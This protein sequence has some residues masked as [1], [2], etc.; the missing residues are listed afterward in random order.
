MTLIKGDNDAK[1]CSK[2]CREEA[3]SKNNISVKPKRIEKEVALELIPIEI[4]EKINRKRIQ[5]R[6]DVVNIN[7]SY[8]NF[9]EGINNFLTSISN[10][11]DGYEKTNSEIIYKSNNLLKGLN[12]Q[13]DKILHLNDIENSIILRRKK[14]METGLKYEALSIRKHIKL[15]TE[16]YASGNHQDQFEN[17]INQTLNFIEQK[18]SKNNYLAT[19]YDRNKLYVRMEEKW[20]ENYQLFKSAKKEEFINICNTKEIPENL[21]IKFYDDWKKKRLIIESSLEPL[22][23]KEFMIT[24]TPYKTKVINRIINLLEEYK[25]AIDKFFVEERL[26]I[27]QR[28]AFDYVG[29]LKEKLDVEYELNKLNMVFQN[30]FMSVLFDIEDYNQKKF[31]V[32]WVYRLLDMQ[33]DELIES[34]GNGI[35]SAATTEIMNAMNQLKENRIREYI[36]DAKTYGAELKNRDKDF[37]SLIFSMRSNLDQIK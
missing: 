1:F 10:G 35:E 8:N 19:H 18:V 32:E 13:S 25:L 36:L 28:Y 7:S 26:Y 11:L 27:H 31:L 2:L 20:V 6:Y 33:L 37:N 9:V 14:I 3:N 29:D 16:K 12:T 21:Q 30:Q 22:L 5:Y 23:K 34:M 15:L 4:K 24:K 17:I